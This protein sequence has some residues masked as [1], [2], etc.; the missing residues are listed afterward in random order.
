MD[1]ADAADSD[2]P[3]GSDQVPPG[4]ESERRARLTPRQA[5]VVRVV[6]AS[7]MMAAMAV[8]LVLRLASRGSVLVVGVYGAALVLC[9]VVIELARNGRTRLGSWLLG[10]GL[11]AALAADWLLLP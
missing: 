2:Q 5:R 9:G 4:G 6:L 1:I 10:I 3:D 11:A 8:L 7:V